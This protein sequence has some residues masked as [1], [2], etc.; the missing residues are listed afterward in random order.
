MELARV[1]RN[2]KTTTIL[3][4][5]MHTLQPQQPLIRSILEEVYLQGNELEL[6]KSV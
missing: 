6:L 5:S 4:L 2:I 1:L 3:T